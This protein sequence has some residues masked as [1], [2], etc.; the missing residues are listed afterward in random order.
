VTCVYAKANDVAASAYEH[1]KT[2][3]QM[4][5]SMRVSAVIPAFNGTRP[6]NDILALSS[7]FEVSFL[8]TST[9]LGTSVT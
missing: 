6:M 7:N 3:T 8:E 9:W 4:T 2:S 5:S 1:C